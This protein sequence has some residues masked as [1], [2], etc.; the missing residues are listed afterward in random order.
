MSRS[1]QTNGLLERLGISEP[2]IQAPM[3]GGATTPELVSAVS[4]AGALGFLGAAYLTAEAIAMAAAE[5]RRRTSRP[6]GINLFAP[7]PEPPAG[8]VS[9]MLE[10][11]AP[12]HASL[13]LPPPE[14]P[15]SPPSTLEAQL[16]AVLATDAAVFSF[17]FGLLPDGVVDRLHARGMLVM[18]TATT[19]DEALQ[20]EARGVDAVVVQGSEAGAHRGTFGGPFEAAMVGTMALV[21]Q[22]VDAVR[23]PVIASGGIMDGRGIAAALAL[24]ASA[25]QLGTA[26]LT[27]PEAGIPASHK[28]AILGGRE[29]ATRITRA[30][31]GRPARGIVTALMDLI[32]AEPDAIP[33]FPLQNALTRPMRTAAAARDDA[34]HLS[35]W[36]GQG[37][38]MA[39]SLPAADLVAAL[40]EEL[41]SASRQLTSASRSRRSRTTR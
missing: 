33:P 31:S 16:D 13:G 30:F 41:A 29:D 35:L 17:T 9:R 19:V 37:V 25:A 4:K 21:P 2:I 11:L 6:F 1:A 7:L 40:A 23:V 15:T 3:A 38:R 10:L 34:A 39:R 27:C 32:D 14:A 12:I 5:V 22:T 18:G 28:H 20:L 36:A 8:D 26:F 24:G